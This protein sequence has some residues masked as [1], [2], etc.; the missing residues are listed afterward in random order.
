LIG[1]GYD[2]VLIGHG[3]DLLLIGGG[4]NDVVVI[5]QGMM[6]SC[7]EARLGNHFVWQAGAPCACFR[8]RKSEVHS[9]MQYTMTKITRPKSQRHHPTLPLPRGPLNLRS[10]ISGLKSLI[11]NSHATHSISDLRS[12][13]SNP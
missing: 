10:P 4:D 8:R 1:G 6:L 13:V 5:G 9:R 12:L 2:V 11:S 7:L 3:N